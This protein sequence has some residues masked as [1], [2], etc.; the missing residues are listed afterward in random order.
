MSFLRR[1][2]KPLIPPVADDNSSYSSQ[3]H[4]HSSTA[5][6]AQPPS[7]KPAS[8]LTRGYSDSDRGSSYS[9]DQP[10]YRAPPKNDVYSRG[11]RDLDTDR[12]E[13]L[14]G[15]KPPSRANRFADG[16]QSQN[17]LEDDDEADEEAI[18]RATRFTKQESVNSTRNALRVA[19][20][21][22]ETGRNTLLRLG[23]QSEKIAN[24]ERHL[25]VAKGL[26]NKAEDR[27]DELKKLNRSIF[28]PA[29]TFNKDA[30]RRAQELKMQNRWEEE[31]D[32]RERAMGD[33]RQT[34]NR[35]GQAA[36]YGL[37]SP[38]DQ[39]D[40]GILAPTGSQSA[41]VRSAESLEQRKRFQVNATASDDELE[42]ELDDNLDEISQ[43][44]NRL[45]TLGIAMGQE[46][47]T[48]I[49]RL[50]RLD[51]KVGRLD[52]KIYNNTEKVSAKC[53]P[54]QMLFYDNQQFKRIK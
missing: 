8:T 5:T 22:E 35:V 41:R 20:E 4:S 6:Y 2:E 51:N 33:I 28:R 12:N 21:A 39:G 24:T 40:E 36:T 42:D 19:R 43:A 45:K 46:L 9:R 15:Y 49:S 1:K 14:G 29:I 38:D 54:C 50:E 53:S 44:T 23:D 27:A 13:L 10:S 17:N 34:Q 25:D 11:E 52:N 3:S 31:K 26:S 32:E 18:Q 30:K 37:N 47:D 16:Y 48:Q 7:Y